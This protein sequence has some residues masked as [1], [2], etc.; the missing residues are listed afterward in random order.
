MNSSLRAIQKGFLYKITCSLVLLCIVQ[1]TLC[2][3]IPSLPVLAASEQHL[4][5]P[6]E[7]VHPLPG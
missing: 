7:H 3:I 5:L 1:H 4:Q 2:K 6:V